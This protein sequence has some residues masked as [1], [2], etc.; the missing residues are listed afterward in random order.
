[1][2]FEQWLIFVAIWTAAGLPLGPS[3]LNCIASAAAGGFR[4]ARWAILG[5]LLA[6]F[7][8]MT[9]TVLGVAMILLANAALFQGLKLVGAAYLIWMGLS[10]WRRKDTAIAFEGP[11]PSS[12]AR[13]LRRAFLIAMS[14]PKAVFAYMAVFSQFVKPD[15]ALAGQLVVLVPSAQ[16]ITAL[17][18]SGYAALGVGI[19][20]WLAT[21]IRRRAFNRG[22]GGAYI[23]GGLGLAA[24]KS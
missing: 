16:V 3:A 24:S 10:M 4:H 14:N 2:S 1:M 7:C 8:H 23:L 12:P 20:R 6:A 5:I 11:V 19:G 13:L 17:V 21:P 15:A 22:L 18:Y 9:A